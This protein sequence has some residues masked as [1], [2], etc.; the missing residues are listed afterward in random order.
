M[1]GAAS[2]RWTP[3]L[4]TTTTPGFVIPEGAPW[5]KLTNTFRLAD[6]AA[7]TDYTCLITNI[8]L[9]PTAGEVVVLQPATGGNFL[10]QVLTVTTNQT[11]QSLRFTAAHG[12]ALAVGD[13]VY[14]TGTNSTPVGAATLRK[15]GD[16]VF[17]APTAR[18]MSLTVDG[19]SAVSINNLSVRY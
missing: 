8:A 2:A 12:V 17:S 1:S 14:A 18:P 9:V 5:H 6:T 15:T 19:T 7:K 4:D 11:F 3:T 16:A 13:L 10:N